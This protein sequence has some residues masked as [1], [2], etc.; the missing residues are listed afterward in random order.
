MSGTDIDHLIRRDAPVLRVTD[1]IASGVR[2]LL[3]AGLPALPVVDENGQLAGIF[4]EREFIEALFPGYLGQLRH[5]AFVPR[6]LDDMLERRKT[7]REE[8]VGKHMNRERIHVSAGGSDIQIAE[9]FLH[10]RVLIVPVVAGRHVSGLITRSDFF[11]E[12]AGRLL[13]SD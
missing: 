5:T 10:H 6:S 7:C 2:V 3:D 13:A 1:P 11:A 4:G 12:A 9:L 8:P